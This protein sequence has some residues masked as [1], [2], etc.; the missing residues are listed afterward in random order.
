[1][2]TMTIGGRSFSGNNV[3]I[4]NG[5]VTI[6]GVLQEGTLSGEVIIKI[7]G[8][9]N[10]LETSHSVNMRGTIKGDVNARG[11]VK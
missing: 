4:I 9:L 7:E 6:D 1:M 5:V 10:S 3:S 8:V 11:S 2:A